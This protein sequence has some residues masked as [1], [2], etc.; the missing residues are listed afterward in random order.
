MA[1]G[2]VAWGMMARCHD[3]TGLV[4]EGFIVLGEKMGSFLMRWIRIGV[5]CH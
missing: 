5:F 1:H 2:M 4:E 3:E